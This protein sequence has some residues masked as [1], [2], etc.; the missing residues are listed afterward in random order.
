MRILRR[1]TFLFLIAAALLCHG[2]AA[3]ATA[4][5]NW[6]GAV[7]L[8]PQKLRI[9]FHL[10][11]DAGGKLTATLDSPDQG[12]NGL[13][14]SGVT[15]DGNTVKISISNLAAS[16]EG[17][18]SEDG[19]ELKGKFRQAGMELPLA[20]SRMSDAELEASKP[21]RPQIP[22]KPYPYDERELTAANKTANGVTLACTLTV[23]RGEGP[24]PAVLAITGSGP[25][26]RNEE[27]A[28]HPVF[29]VLADQLTRKGI[30]VLRCDDRGVGK[31]TGDFKAA[32][33]ADFATDVEAEFDVLKTQ[34]KVDPKRCGLIGHSEGGVIAPMVA[35][36][37]PDVGFIVLLSGPGAT[38]KQ[39][40]ISQKEAIL[41]AAGVSKPD[42][43]PDLAMYDAILA[44]KDEA[45]VAA[46]AEGVFPPAAPETMKL[47]QIRQLM[48]PWFRYFLAY[49]PAPTLAKVKQPVLALFGEKDLQVL[50]AI[51]EPPIRAALKDNKQA[52]I[53][54]IPG[55]NHLFQIAKTGAPAEYPN[56]EE[57]ISPKALNVVSDWILALK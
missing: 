42:M 16:Y 49:D 26:D 18:L 51:N 37:R 2:Q 9:I 27:V 44:G 39:V 12:A 10:K 43:S 41:K 15:Q 5:G 29:L 22:A 20:L 30:A 33:T 45:A 14:T 4:A 32:T 46:A 25:H 53:E 55:A 11:A 17:V 38:G 34:S 50:P 8:G 52:K 31:S 48:S 6:S 21:K 19:K 47:Q 54:T 36:R 28:S 40:I 35:A 13:P 24:F 1:T 3:T 57:T 23:P 56:I 7:S